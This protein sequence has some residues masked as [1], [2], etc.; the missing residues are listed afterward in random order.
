[1]AEFQGLCQIVENSEVVHLE[2]CNDTWLVTLDN[3][4]DSTYDVIWLATGT[5]VDVTQQPLFESLMKTHPCEL[6]HGMARFTEHLQWRSDVPV[7]SPRTLTLVGC[8]G[9]PILRVFWLR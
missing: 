5:I 9:T 2:R 8:G 7:R 3:G 1:M 6:H 4:E